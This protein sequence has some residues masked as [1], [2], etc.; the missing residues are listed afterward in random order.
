MTDPTKLRLDLPLVLPDVDD[1]EDRCVGRLT[2]ALTGRPGI[3]TAHIVRSPAN[4]FQ[5]CVHYDPAVISLSRLRE[6]VSSVGGRLG[7]R[8][9]HLVFR[10][11]QSMH[12]R[13]SASNR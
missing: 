4:D 10:A 3:D 12:V 1:P 8:F 11:D 5:L 9:S 7:E 13:D 2:E 6:L